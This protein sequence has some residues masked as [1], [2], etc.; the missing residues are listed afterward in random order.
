MSKVKVLKTDKQR[1]LLTEV[2]PYEVPIPFSNE[3]IYNYARRPKSEKVPPLITALLHPDKTGKKSLLPYSY[4]IIKDKD[5]TRTLSIMHPGI[6][7][8]FVKFYK[9]YDALIISICSKSKVSIRYPKKVASHFFVKNALVK[10]NKIRDPE[11]ELEANYFDPDVEYS[12]SYFTYKDFDF[13]YKFYDSY[14]F[15]RL[16]KKFKHLLKFDLSKCFNSIYT[17]SIA[18][19]VKNKVFA[20]N[21]VSRSSFENKFDKLMQWSNYNETNGI[22]IGPEISRIFAEIILQKVESNVIQSLFENDNSGKSRSLRIEVDYSI[23][24]YVDDYFVF[25]NDQKIAERIKREFVDELEFFKLSVN[26]FKT[27][28]LDIPFITGITIARI[29]IE[30]LL[31]SF[32]NQV[33]STVPSASDE[34][35]E[36]VQIKPIKRPY[37]RS[38]RL[39]RDL[40]SIIKRNDVKYENITGKT[41]SNLRHRIVNLLSE[42]EIN[43]NVEGYIE[44]LINLLVIILDF[45]FFIVSMDTRTRVT[46]LLAQ[47]VVVILRFLNNDKVKGEYKRFIAKRIFD[48]L[49][50]VFNQLMIKDKKHLEA[51]NLL[52]ALA[53]VH[54]IYQ[55]DKSVFVTS[56]YNDKTKIHALDYFQI[57]ILLYF[58]EKESK[59]DSVREDIV[60]YAL[61]KFEK[62][63]KVKGKTEMVLLFFDIIACPYVKKELKNDIIKVVYKGEHGTDMNDSKVGELRNYVSKKEKWFIDWSTD[64]VDLEFMLLKKEHSPPYSN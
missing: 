38:N 12:S 22:L 24:R 29:E 56:Y 9:D 3:A 20:K 41:L 28:L 40:K 39:I 47:I 48:G 55:F 19:A 45:I 31:E 23:R 10:K 17:H 58:L 64:D 21:N 36:L 53:H 61:L 34:E 49:R 50:D 51:L 43:K 25:T 5:S 30:S 26:E 42:S 33:I 62:E 60:N 8:E 6:Q 16:E 27:E 1:I 2:L 44:G 52:V 54:K 59:Y 46:V 4:K 63:R 37:D 18:W 35:Q 32:F 57:V 15:H 14:K 13:L 11:V 7:M